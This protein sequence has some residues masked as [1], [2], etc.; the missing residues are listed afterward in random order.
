L[1]SGEDQFIEKGHLLVMPQVDAGEVPHVRQRAGEE[2]LVEQRPVVVV[3][4]RVDAAS[5][6]S[7][8]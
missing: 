1:L 6:K 3:G 8:A 7:L 2:S 5:A 4:D